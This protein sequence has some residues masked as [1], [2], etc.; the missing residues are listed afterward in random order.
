MTHVGHTRINLPGWETIDAHVKWCERRELR[1]RTVFSRREVCLKLTDRLGADLLDVTAAQVRAWWEAH[2]GVAGTRRFDLLH[3]RGFYRWAI[4]EGLRADDPTAGLA[5]PKV[6]R[7][8]PRPMSEERTN[9]AIIYAPARIKPWL[10]LAAYAGLRAC[11][12]ATLEAEDIRR[13]LGVLIVRE[14]KG[15][16]QRAIPMHPIVVE[17]LKDAPASGPVFRKEHRD[18]PINARLVS[19]IANNWLRRIGADGTFHS[20]RHRFATRVYAVSGDLRITQELMGHADPQTTAIYT[21]I[22]PTKAKSAVDSI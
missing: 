7:G 6:Q 19:Q 12:V 20:L 9:A 1:P 13:D 14:G 3:L 22:S 4:A 8:I 15:G 21:A 5:L 17:A 10:V 11:E 18:E 2:T 16:K